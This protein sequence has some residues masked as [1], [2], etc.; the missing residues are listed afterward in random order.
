M[1][2]QRI[3]KPVAAAAAADS[4]ESG[5]ESALRPLDADVVRLLVENHRR[6]RAFV[7]RRIGNPELAD[8]LVQNSLRRALE[9]PPSSTEEASVLAW[10]HVI[11]RN[12]IADHF[13][14]QASGSDREAELRTLMEA[15]GT[16][17][18]RAMDDDELKGA[19]CA[20]LGELIEALKPEYREVVRRVELGG[21]STADVATHLGVSRGNLDVRLHRARKALR[22]ALE[23]SCGACTVHGC[24][25]CSC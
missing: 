19:A 16:D 6:F 20:C 21:E 5:E 8:D 22:V 9:R 25:D 3:N 7:A 11:L 2:T 15:E 14:L 10:F 1:S 23:K 24:L 13:R 4:A 18:T 17:H 12:A